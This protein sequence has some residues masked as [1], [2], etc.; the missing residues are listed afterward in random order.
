MSNRAVTSA[1]S[2]PWRTHWALAQ[3]RARGPRRRPDR[4]AGA[5]FPGHHRHTAVKLDGDRFD[6]G[7]VT[8]AEMG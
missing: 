8:D 6:D 4:F 3:R 5:S 7:E 1:R 2:A